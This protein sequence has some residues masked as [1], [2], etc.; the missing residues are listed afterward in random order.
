MANKLDFANEII[1]KSTEMMGLAKDLS[2]LNEFYFD[3]G[4]DSGGA[5]PI[6]DD[7]V[8]ESDITAAEIADVVNFAGYLSTWLNNGVPFQADWSATLN[9]VRNVKLD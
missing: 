1:Q 3:N 8:S 2:D 4:L 9:K 6:I 5:D 7:D